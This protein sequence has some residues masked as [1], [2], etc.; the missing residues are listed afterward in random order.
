MSFKYAYTLV[1]GFPGV[2]F[3]EAHLYIGNIFL[4]SCLLYS[5]PTYCLSLA[6]LSNCH[7]AMDTITQPPLGDD[8]CISPQSLWH[9]VGQLHHPNKAIQHMK[10]HHAIHSLNCSLLSV[11]PFLA[12]AL[13]HSTP[14]IPSLLNLRLLSLIVVNCLIWVAV[15]SWTY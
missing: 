8:Y 3:G 15:L 13:P 11:S 10:G 2:T 14:T 7:R 6:T 9:Y 5:D 4:K 12:F 1:A